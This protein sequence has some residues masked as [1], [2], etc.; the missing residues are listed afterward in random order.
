MLDAQLVPLRL[1][2]FYIE[3]IQFS[4]GALM[5]ALNSSSKGSAPSSSPIPSQPSSL[6]G[7]DGVTPTIMIK[8][9]EVITRPFRPKR[10]LVRVDEVVD[11]LFVLG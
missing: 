5:A 9:I 1:V 2:K 11:V 8:G 3:E 6:E 4:F 7:K 10:D